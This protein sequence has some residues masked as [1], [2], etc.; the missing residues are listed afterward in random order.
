MKKFIG[1]ALLGLVLLVMGGVALQ[2][3]VSAATAIVYVTSY[4]T[5]SG[6]DVWMPSSGV[7]VWF[8][9]LDTKDYGQSRTTV[10]G[11]PVSIFLIA[12]VSYEVSDDQ[13]FPKLKA[14]FTVAPN[15]KIY[16]AMFPAEI[17]VSPMPIEIP[18]P[19]IITATLRDES[20]NLITASRSTNSYTVRFYINKYPDLFAFQTD[21]R[22]NVVK[23]Y[24]QILT[25]SGKY[26][27]E[28]IK[29]GY[30]GYYK[31]EAQLLNGSSPLKTG[32]STIAV[33][34]AASKPTIT[35]TLKP[36]PSH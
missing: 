6:A 22:S 16:I 11:G 36:Y 25:Y 9:R 31:I 13:Y 7:K 35:L 34:V 32:G 23:Q 3:P 2:Q 26:V 18:G 30:S 10:T 4:S 14:Y 29:S 1:L 28:P 8:K 19:T 33:G 24:D 20:G 27:L 21:G 12:G 17:K 5:G 15:G